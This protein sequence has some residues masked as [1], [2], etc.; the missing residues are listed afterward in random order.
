VSVVFRVSACA[1]Q[2][3]QRHAAFAVPFGARDLGAAQTAG[4]GDAD[5]FGAHAEGPLNGALHGAAESDT[6][7]ELVGDTL[8]DEARVNLRL[9]DLDDVEADFAVGHLR[10][11]LL[12]LLD[13]AALLA[14]D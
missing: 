8:R 10:Q 9:A 12:Q 11:R 14:D 4:A 3:M 6:A 5:A 2:R 7:L 1:A 13:V